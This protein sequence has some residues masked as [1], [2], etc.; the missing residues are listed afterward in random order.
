MIDLQP[1]LDAAPIV[2]THIFTT[3]FALGVGRLAVFRR[4]RDGWH[5]FMGY[6]WVLAMATL[7]LTPFLSLGCAQFSLARSTCC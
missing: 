7:A 6:L 1:F 4:R 3:F 2:Q 5:K